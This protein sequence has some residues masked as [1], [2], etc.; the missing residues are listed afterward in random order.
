MK[1]HVSEDDCGINLLSK[2]F[3]CDYLFPEKDF[4]SPIGRAKK[5]GIH[6]TTTSTTT[7]C[8]LKKYCNDRCRLSTRMLL[9]RTTITNN[10]AQCR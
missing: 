1:M 3:D 8:C 10:A 4:A 7:H 2:H 9:I 5:E 6:P